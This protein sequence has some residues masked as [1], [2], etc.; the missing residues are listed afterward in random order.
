MENRDVENMAAETAGEGE[1]ATA[2]DRSQSSRNPKDYNIIDWEGP[3]DPDKPVNWSRRRQYTNIIFISILT[4][5][6]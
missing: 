6:T 5:L 3:N 1:S 2:S 4:L